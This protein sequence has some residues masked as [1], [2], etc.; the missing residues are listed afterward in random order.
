VARGDGWA[1]ADWIR[2]AAAATLVVEIT[3]PGNAETDR[4]RKLR[5]YAVGDVPLYLLIE[6]G[7]Q[8]VTL[9]SDPHD[10]LYRAHTQVGFGAVLPL[11]KPFEGGLDTGILG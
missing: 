6:T 2:L 1:G 4:V 7:D 9:F 3:S 8:T 11:P 5:G 10:G